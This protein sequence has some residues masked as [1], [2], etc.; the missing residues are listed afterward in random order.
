MAAILYFLPG[1]TNE[2]VVA[3]GKLNPDTLE[4]FGLAEILRD[5]QKVPHHASTNEHRKG[6]PDGKPGVLIAPVSKH[7]GPP[8]M[9]TYKPGHQVWLPTQKGAYAGYIK[10]E[11]PTSYDLERLSVSRGLVVNDQHGFPWTVPIARSPQ[12]L[13]GLLPKEYT[14]DSEGAP[15]GR[16][17]PTH[18]WLW[19]LAGELRDYFVRE[20]DE[21]YETPSH[22]WLITSVLR[23]LGVHYRLGPTEINL[24]A[25]LGRNPLSDEFAINVAAATVHYDIYV[26]A[27]KKA[28]ESAAVLAE[29]SSSSPPGE[30]AEC[31][32]T[33]RVGEP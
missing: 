27:K 20:G 8:S 30:E 32:S 9:F 24:L 15:E 21:Q 11:P 33:D 18:T 14:F 17:Q 22:K 16:V 4:R 28:P 10:V 13:Y 25:D 26:E 3:D 12:D 6:G 2:Q 7:N 29:S 19:E 23:V 1:V 5:V 31:Q